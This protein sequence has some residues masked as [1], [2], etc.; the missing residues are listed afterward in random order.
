MRFCSHLSSRGLHSL[1][2]SFLNNKS[3]IDTI[4][5]WAM[6]SKGY[7]ITLKLQ[8]YLCVYRRTKNLFGVVLVEF[9]LV[10]NVSDF[11]HSV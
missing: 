6:L 11:F 4:M 2:T 8:R 1:S 3:G 5:L 7:K 9:L 10:R